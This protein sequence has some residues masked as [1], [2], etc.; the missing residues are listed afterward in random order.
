MSRLNP[1]ELVCA[2]GYRSPVDAYAKLAKVRVPL[3]QVIQSM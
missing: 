3:D 2:A 1:I